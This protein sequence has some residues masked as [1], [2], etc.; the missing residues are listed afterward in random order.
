MPKLNIEDLPW[1]R[2][3]S[4]NGRFRGSHK[5][6]S[7]ALGADPGRPVGAGGHPLDL[8]LEKLAPGECF[9]P[10]HAH[11]AQW[12]MF[13]ILRGSATVRT[14]EGTYQAHPGDVILHPPNEAHQMMN[15]GTEDVVYLI[16]AD[17]PSLDVCSYPDSEKLSI[18]GAPRRV[19][20]A[21]DVDY[22]DGEE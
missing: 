17:N 7:Q 19:V 11:A 8:A 16:I 14:A 20:R 18:P 22:Y 2:F 6:L 10:F 21:V 4:P 9:C 1:Q 5:E 15:G 13:Y 3:V 12:E